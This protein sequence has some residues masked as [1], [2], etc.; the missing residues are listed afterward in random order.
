M[1]P[2]KGLSSQNHYADINSATI[3]TTQVICIAISQ[4]TDIVVHFRWNEVCYF[5]HLWVSQSTAQSPAHS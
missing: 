2:L 1:I 4:R 5:T 3:P